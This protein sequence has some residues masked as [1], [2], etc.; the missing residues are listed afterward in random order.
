MLK[1]FS[2]LVVWTFAPSLIFLAIGSQL[3]YAS[4]QAR[5]RRLTIRAQQLIQSHT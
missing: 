5:G 1:I 3:I 2:L 4:Q